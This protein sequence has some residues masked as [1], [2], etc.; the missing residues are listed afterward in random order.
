MLIIDRA[1]VQALL[2]LDQLVDALG[3]AMSDLSE[4]RVSMPGR[5][6]ALVPGRDAFLAA[7][8][9]HV[10]SLGALAAK[11][12]SV[13]PENAGGPL[14]THQGAILV[15]D[16]ESGEPVALMDAAY[17]TAVRTAAGSALATRL[18]ARP[19]ASTLA[20]IGTGVQAR[21]HARAIPRVRAIDD[22]RVAGRDA[23]KAAALADEL[24][25]DSGLPARPAASYEEAVRGADI[26]CATTHSPEPVVRREWLAPGVHVNS[27]GDNPGGR[28]LDDGTVGVSVGV[29]E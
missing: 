3:A 2:D 14:P 13:F 18:L 26:V 23:A 27:V 21:A 10:P 6:A 7:M 15:F 20:I 12:M 17:I 29:V 9:S 28:E 16:P 25:R 19:D 24:A 1:E 22:I 5:M 4:G 11:L 8:V